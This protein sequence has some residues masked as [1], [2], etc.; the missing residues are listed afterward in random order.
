MSNSNWFR[1][2]FNNFWDQLLM[3]FLAVLVCV[4]I[5]SAFWVADEHNVRPVWVFLAWNSIL[6]IP[7]F[8]RN[9]RGQLKRPSFVGFLTVWMVGHGLFVVS[10]MRWVPYAY[11]VPLF[12]LEFYAGYLIA[13][14]LFGAVPSEKI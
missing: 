10:L 1:N 7:L 6:M 13:Y 4:F 5:L 3:A 2:L 8:I 14:W 9:F 12:V 11:W